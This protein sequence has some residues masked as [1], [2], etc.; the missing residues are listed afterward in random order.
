MLIIHIYIAK[1]IQL[2]NLNRL[3]IV[4]M[5]NN[6]LIILKLCELNPL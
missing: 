2:Q 6:K 4:K 3:K 1:Y 5:V